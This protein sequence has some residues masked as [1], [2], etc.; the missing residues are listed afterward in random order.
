MIRSGFAVLA[1]RP[2]V[3]KST[4]LNRFV[5]HKVA[6]TSS[7]PQTTRNRIAGVVHRPG[8]QVVFLDTPGLHEPRHRLGEYMVGVARATLGEVDVICLVV[9]GSTPPGP[10]DQAVARLIA[11][12]GRRSPSDRTSRVPAEPWTAEAPPAFLLVNKMDRVDRNTL[13]E[14]LAAYAALGDFAHVVPVSAASGENCDRALDL[15]VAELPEGPEYYP[16]DA[17]TDQPEQV[18]VAELV[19]E[20]VLRRTRDEVPHAV[21]VR[22]DRW[23]ER[24]GPMVHVAATVYVERESQKGILIGRNGQM[25]KEIGAAA[26]QEAEAL[27]GTRMFLE[28]WVKVMK[29]WR[30]RPS[31][32]QRLGYRE[33]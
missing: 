19:R 16:Q 7:L 24:P 28:L 25:L 9:D 30:D 10:S 17:Y 8:A 1:G 22:V 13:I 14:R 5:G 12:G 15:I 29:D 27:L 2:N 11:A 32:L 26:R 21:A 3:G 18:L 23:V 20:Q 31:V 6:I 4:L 33:D